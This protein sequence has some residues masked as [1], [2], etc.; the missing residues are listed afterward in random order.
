MDGPR[1]YVGLDV[2]E[3]T[4]AVAVACPGRAEPE[5]RGFLPNRSSSL[6]RLMRGLQGPQR[7][8]LSFAYEAGPCGYGGCT[9][10]SPERVTIAK[11]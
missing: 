2:R 9:A 11:S 5:Y 6:M 1:A 3:E 8:A 7:E 4:I 10:A